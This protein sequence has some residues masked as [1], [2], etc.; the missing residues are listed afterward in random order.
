MCGLNTGNTKSAE[1]LEISATRLQRILQYAY[2]YK[3]GEPETS[4]EYLSVLLDHYDI[5]SPMGIDRSICKKEYTEFVSF[6]KNHKILK[7]CVTLQQL[8]ESAKS[9][10]KLFPNITKLF[11]H[12]LVLPVSTVDCE[13]CFSVVK[14]VKTALRNRMKPASLPS[15][16]QWLFIIFC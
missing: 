7:K 13:R 1:P 15:L 4:M 10:I 2:T 11:V 5:E 9:I 16:E 6:V 12:A 8:S 14:R 3:L